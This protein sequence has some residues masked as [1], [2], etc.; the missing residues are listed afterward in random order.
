MASDREPPDREPKWS[1][2]VCDGTSKARLGQALSQV[3]KYL[4][5][6][7]LIAVSTEE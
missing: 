4:G 5:T 1:L 3:S 7:V 2:E 6:E